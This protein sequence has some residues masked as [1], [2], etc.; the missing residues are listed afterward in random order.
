M[1][2]KYTWIKQNVDDRDYNYSKLT[3]LKKFSIVQLPSSASNIQWCSP[4]ENQGEL[5]SCT[6]NAW[7][8]LLQFNEI[9]AGRDYKDLSRL[10][11]YFNERDIEGSIMEDSGAQLRDGAK[12]LATKGVCFEDEWPY[13]VTKFTVKPSDDC[14]TIAQSNII[15]SYYSL[16][17]LTDMKACIA[18]GNC[19]VFGFQVFDSFESQEVADTG[20]L[21]IPL[22]TEECLG[23]HAVCAVG[24]DDATQRFTIRNSWGNEWG[25][26]GYFTMPYE[27]ITNPELASDFW[28]CVKEI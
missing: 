14:Y 11:I 13:D 22:E 5:G 28:T 3:N 23:G 20:I 8:G 6:A 24:Y 25:Q 26:N 16:Q 1:T 2:R 4:I 7:A 9:K 21:N 17:T 27:Y 19:F 10:F 15:H 18:N 12:A